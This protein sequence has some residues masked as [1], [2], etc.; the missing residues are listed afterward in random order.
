M[1]EETVMRT[2]IISAVFS[3]LGMVAASQAQDIGDVR[4]GRELALDVCASCHAV[5]AGQTQSPLATAPSFEEIAHMPGMTA[6][7]LAFWLTAQSHP[8]MPNLILSPQQVRNV[9][10]YLLSLRD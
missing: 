10:A 2:L 3:I 9:S 1:V 8:T 7:A 5:G 4:Q 6:A